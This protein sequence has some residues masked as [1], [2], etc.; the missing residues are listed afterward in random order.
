M[1]KI[2]NFIFAI[3][4]SILAFAACQKEVD[5]TDELKKVKVVVSLSEETKA[6]FADL[7]GVKWE[8]GDILKFSDG[9]TSWQSDPLALDKI[10]NSGHKA[11]FTF[12][13][14]LISQAR[15]GWFY[16]PN[17]HPVASNFNDVQYPSSFTQAVAGEMSK[18]YLFLHSGTSTVNITQGVEP[19]EIQLKI[20][21]SIF[22][23]IPYTSTYN[24]ESVE[25]VGI[26]SNSNIAGTV[27]YDRTSATPLNNSGLDSPLI[28]LIIGTYFSLTGI[29]TANSSEGFYIPVPATPAETPYDGYAYVVETAQAEY[30]FDAGAFID[31]SSP[32]SPLTVGENKV[33]NVFLDLNKATL[34]NDKTGD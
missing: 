20:V 4:I 1:K 11:T 31:P 18:D 34:R 3:A 2:L 7:G 12:S 24:S 6:L 32:K 33:I 21:G 23:I 10:T 5:K 28:R 8:A 17:T 25:A 14:D 15:I 13:E 22:R 26:I 30:F 27:S 16:T 19:S 29:T 9:T